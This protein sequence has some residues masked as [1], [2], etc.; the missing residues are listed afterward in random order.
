MP[1]SLAETLHE[2]AKTISIQTTTGT[3]E[4]VEVMVPRGVTSGTQIKYP[5]LGDNMFNTLPRG[6]LF[7]QITVHANDNFHVSNGIDLHTRFSV[8]CLTAI[9]G[10]VAE[11]VGLDNKKF[12][13]AIPPGTQPNVKFR[14]A[15]QGIYQMHSEHRGDLYAEMTVTVPKNLDQQQL[16]TIQN[17]LNS[18]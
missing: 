17:I 16:D 14:L 15:Q 7:V 9:V 10:G 11:V 8:N 2:Q 6:D 5:G 12:T 4:A 1:I 18:N 3:R 13:I